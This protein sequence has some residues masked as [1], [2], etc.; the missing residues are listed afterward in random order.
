MLNPYPYTLQNDISHTDKSLTNTTSFL[1]SIQQKKPKLEQEIFLTFEDVQ[2]NNIKSH[3]KF[4]SL[5]IFGT[6]LS[7]LILIIASFYNDKKFFTEKISCRLFFF[8]NF[9]INL[10]INIFL[11]VF[12]ILSLQFFLTNKNNPNFE[13]FTDKTFAVTIFTTQLFFSVFFL[14]GEKKTCGKKM[15]F[16]IK[17]LLILEITQYISQ[18]FFS[19]YFLNK[20]KKEYEM[21]IALDEE[22]IKKSKNL[23]N[24]EKF[25]GSFLL[26]LSL[27]AP[28]AKEE[29]RYKR[30]K[31]YT[32]RK[33]SNKF[34]I[35]DL[36]HLEIVKKSKEKKF[37]KMN[38]KLIKFNTPTKDLT[39]RFKNI[40]VDNNEKI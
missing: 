21:S 35:Y 20:I 10:L 19:L 3:K 30:K 36:D 8:S 27:T 39:N 40:D 6:L 11:I 26:N 13:M 7:N 31:K 16:K 12:Q 22:S 9:Y 5:F 38:K 17:I 23:K 4:T 25:N 2:K 32:P 34:N 14:T 18:L 15:F 33:K 37:R 1:S 29:M 24:K 28:S